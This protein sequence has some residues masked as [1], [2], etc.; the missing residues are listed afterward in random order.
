MEPRS[1]SGLFVQIGVTLSLS[2][3]PVTLSLSKD[4]VTLSLSKDPVTLSLSKG[5]T[6]T[7]VEPCSPLP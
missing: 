4:P 3:D 7:E 2:K 5:D 1:A 6:R